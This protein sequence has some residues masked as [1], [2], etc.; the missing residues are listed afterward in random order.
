MGI[1]LALG[2][3]GASVRW[4]VVRETLAVVAAGVAVGLPVSLAA[5]PVLK[6]MLFGVMPQDPRSI[7]AGVLLLVVVGGFAGYLPARRAAQVDPMRCCAG[8]TGSL[9]Q[10]PRA[11]DVAA[12][13][14]M[15]WQPR[16][17]CRLV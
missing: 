6:T 5:A 10:R 4:L 13:G 7:V 14:S 12:Q 8:V 17:P 2:A 9:G 16:A 1:R 11:H 3:S 15:T